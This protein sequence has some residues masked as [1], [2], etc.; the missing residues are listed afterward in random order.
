MADADRRVALV[1]DIAAQQRVVEEMRAFRGVR[2]QL[3]D[4]VRALKA[5]VARTQEALATSPACTAARRPDS[6]AAA[7]AAVAAEAAPADG[8]DAAPDR[9]YALDFDDDADDDARRCEGDDGPA[10]ATDADLLSQVLGGLSRRLDAVRVTL[11]EHAAEAAAAATAASADGAFIPAARS[12][13]M[14]A[15]AL[16]LPA[17]RF[18]DPVVPTPASLP[19]AD[20][21]ISDV[22]AEPPL[23]P[24]PPRIPWGFASVP[25]ATLTG[26]RPGASAASDEAPRGTRSPP[27]AV[28]AAAAAIV[29]E[30][31]DTAVAMDD[32]ALDVPAD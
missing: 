21:G 9:D 2:L 5:A 13:P 18:V 19:A 8:G 20:A 16:P 15:T 10:A 24:S 14:M 1:A 11:F 4:D 3:A 22:E 7:A 17:P 27:T 23:E 32:D 28:A 30:C 12:D 31:D 26:A 6:A 25:A 29:V